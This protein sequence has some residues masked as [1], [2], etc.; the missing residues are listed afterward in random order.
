MS[1]PSKRYSL[2]PAQSTSTT[3]GT[4]TESTHNL[5]RR[6]ITALNKL[7]DRDTL[8][9]AAAELEGIARSLSHDSFSPFLNCIH[10]TDS[11]SKSPVRKQC[12]HLLTVL[13]NFHGDALSPFLSKMISTII[14]RIRDPDS[15]VRSACVDA[16]TAMSSRITKP[17]FSAFLKP[18]M[19]A[20]TQEQDVNSQI[21]AALC[22]AAA[23]ESAPEPDVESLRKSTL[24]KLGKLAKN[25]VC[26]AKAAVL[27]LIGSVVGVGG[28]SC[29]GV[30]NWLVPSLI[31]F[32][33]SED[34][35]VR[36]AAA[37][38][39]GKVAL[40][41]NDLV[42]QYKAQCLD[43]LQNRRFDKVLNFNLLLRKSLT[44]A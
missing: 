2:S 3:T 43:T 31:D 18:L 7:A 19:E 30:L 42:S 10:N 27:V 22:L 17:P 36:K 4:T 37:E 14:R 28:A 21:G 35:T 34:W 33:G 12:V 5:K 26:K 15:A 11:S 13:S 20:L 29:R 1:F 38:A 44:I 16:V 32:L 23:I 25:E 40:V 8:A 41:G 39:L 6:V 9:V 24:P